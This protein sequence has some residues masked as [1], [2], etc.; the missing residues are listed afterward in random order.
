MRVYGV[1]PAQTAP[2]HC[3]PMSPGN[4]A[5]NIISDADL[6]ALET[7]VDAL[8]RLCDDLRRENHGLRQ[9]QARLIDERAGLIERNDLARARVEAIISRLKAL[10]ENA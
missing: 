8:I 9:E 6:S 5:P 7:R 1:D 2:E 3:P 10:E 4:P